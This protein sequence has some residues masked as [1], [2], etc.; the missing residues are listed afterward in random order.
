M[1]ITAMPSDAMNISL[2]HPKQTSI[3]WKLLGAFVV[4]VLAALGTALMAIQL[5]LNAAER[6]AALEAEHVAKA[7]ANTGT[8][9]PIDNPRVLQKYVDRLGS[10]FDRDIIIV[11][12]HG[13]VI[14]DTN[15]TAI[16]S[17]Y[18]NA[19]I[20]MTMLDSVSRTFV[21]PDATQPGMAKQVVV[22]LRANPAE[23]GSP[24]VGAIIFEYTLL[25]D[26]LM[27]EARRA[28]YMTGVVMLVLISIG[29]LVAVRVTRSIVRP[30]AKLQRGVAAIANEHY[31]TRVEVTSRDEIGRLA[32]AFNKMAEDLGHS[33]KALKQR[34]LELAKSNALLQDGIAQQKQSAERIQYLA[35]HDSLTGLPNRA[36]FN[37]VL[38]KAIKQAQRHDRQ[39]GLFFIDLDRF[40]QI[41][42]TLGHEAGDLLLQEVGQR[43]TQGLRASDTVARLGGD[44]F[45]VL[46][47]DLADEHQAQS[48]AR[49]ILA[50]VSKPFLV[51]GQELRVTAS[52]GIS[53]FPQ[54]G[55]DE[56]TLMKR[57]D[58]AM[59]QA[60]ENGR[61]A[62]K[63][64]DSQRDANSFERLSME[65]GLRRALERN[66]LELH[67]QAK[68]DIWT[69]ATS[70]M[71]A[72]LRWNHP[73]LGN[74][75]PT[76][77]IPVAEETG[78]IVPIG[79]WVLRT[80]CLQTM[81]W[82]TRGLTNLV[83]A[84]NLSPRQFADENLL[85]NIIEILEETG[86]DAR[87]LELEITE[88]TIMRDPAKGRQLLMTLKSMGVRIAI[89]DF[90]TGY[91]SLSTLKQLPIDTL[92]I[93]RSFVR[94]LETNADDRGLTEAII[95]LAKT[96][97][98]H[99]VAEGVE[100]RAQADFLRKRGCDELQGY[101]FSKPLPAKE[102]AR[103]VSRHR[104]SLLEIKDLVK[105][106]NFD[107]LQSFTR[108]G[109]LA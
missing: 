77:F 93:D 61:N 27:Q 41:N 95:T 15:A 26:T 58:V 105:S 45:V 103:F 17:T 39:F 96:L 42:D 64:Y 87:H 7:I 10:M 22:P 100:T 88:S 13:E 48:V 104:A 75:P 25:Y 59:Y 109:A 67:Y 74:V 4:V 37:I 85:V 23:N 5:Q 14:A 66:E 71:E 8:E 79:L 50:A 33:R 65:A 11:N 107:D 34:A 73:E 84:V 60:K 16:G 19:E 21:G 70:G 54:D 90:G 92:K 80:A 51:P 3:R 94:D 28:G 29:W 97:K 63:F 69:G 55:I 78:L 12:R 91:S 102:F 56:H 6:A 38:P 35:Y 18:M 20:A 98:L 57:S 31:D 44:E 1:H 89:D 52:I 2:L 46:V 68:R 81:D 101:Y 24:A 99:L 72:L 36:M 49:K 76:Q 106:T 86:M 43:L 53:R 47:P 82:H 62:F 30:L 9:N 40:K 83:V 108:P 32:A